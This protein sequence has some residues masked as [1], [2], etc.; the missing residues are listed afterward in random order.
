[1]TKKKNKD[2]EYTKE[3]LTAR[4]A[5][6]VK[7]KEILNNPDKYGINPKTAA[8]WLALLN[9]AQTQP[10]K[11]GNGVNKI[12]K[13]LEPHMN[14][15]QEVTETTG[16]EPVAAPQTVVG[17]APAVN[18]FEPQPVPPPTPLTRAEATEGV[19]PVHAD[20]T[21]DGLALALK[22]ANAPDEGEE[23]RSTKPVTDSLKDKVEG[24]ALG[25]GVPSS[26]S[27]DEQEPA[28]V[29]AEA[30]KEP[31]GGGFGEVTVTTN[32]EV[33]QEAVAAPAPEREI[34]PDTTATP[35]QTTGGT[36]TGFFYNIY[37]WYYG[38]N[39]APPATV[40]KTTDLVA[41]PEVAPLTEVYPAEDLVIYHDQQ[42]AALAPAPQVEVETEAGDNEAVTVPVTP[43]AE[44]DVEVELVAQI[45]PTANDA[46]PVATVG[47]MPHPTEFEGT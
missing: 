35:Q 29:D 10:E 12:L 28:K 47:N 36:W 32:T 26:P 24:G 30:H 40:D 17:G 41:R 38:G 8:G 11:M 25:D 9:S 34:V 27:E 23:T 6:M 21:G 4:E 18:L 45:D 42:E 14:Q 7:A 44:D 2:I 13:I 3:Q 5:D 19:G 1:M 20:N 22:A 15:G 37:N 46:A 43:E 16:V 31:Y 39:D 33:P